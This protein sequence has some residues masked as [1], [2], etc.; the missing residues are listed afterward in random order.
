MGNTNLAL[1]VQR[2][3]IE[4]EMLKRYLIMVENMI[5]DNM[6]VDCADAG[7]DIADTGKASIERMNSLLSQ[8]WQ[9][10]YDGKQARKAE[11]EAKK[12]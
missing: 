3:K 12:L 4:Q 5:E 1:L 9:E 7:M 2:V 11:E 6:T 10:F 8:I